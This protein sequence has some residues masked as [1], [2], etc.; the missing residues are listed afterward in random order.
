ML[1]HSQRFFIKLSQDHSSAKISPFDQIPTIRYIQLLDLHLLTRVNIIL[2]V[3]FL[4]QL[5]QQLLSLLRNMH[6]ASFTS[7]LKLVG[8]HHVGS[9]D[10]VSDYFGA[11][12]AAD[13]GACVDADTHVQTV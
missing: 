6:L 4:L 7:L 8:Y 3:R 13:Y 10:V 9:V 11:Y 12:D 2:R 5:I 1:L